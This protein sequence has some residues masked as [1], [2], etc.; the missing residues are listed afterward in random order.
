MVDSNRPA[1]DVGASKTLGPCRP[2]TGPFRTRQN[3]VIDHHQAHSLCG[4]GQGPGDR[5]VLRARTRILGRMGV[6]KSERSPSM[7]EDGRQH[8]TTVEKAP[9][10]GAGGETLDPQNPVGGVEHDDERFLP[11]RIGD[12]AANRGGDVSGIADASDRGGLGRRPPG[13]QAR[14][15]P[16]A[17][18][19]WRDQWRAWRRDRGGRPRPASPSRRT[20]SEVLGPAPGRC[21]PARRCAARAQPTQHP[22]ACG[23]QGGRARSRGLSCSAIWAMD[24]VIGSP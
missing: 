16:P 13:G 14:R 1:R 2:E 3:D 22:S 12:P 11:G 8:V 4:A 10:L 5:E 9:A 7:T 21:I 23:V 17:T 18:R 6:D 19:P 15:R 20:R 24:T